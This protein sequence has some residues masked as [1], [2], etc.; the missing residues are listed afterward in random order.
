MR[1][2]AIGPA[3]ERLKK[4]G[5]VLNGRRRSGF[6]LFSVFSGAIRIWLWF[7]PEICILVMRDG[8]VVFLSYIPQENAE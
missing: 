5:K 2:T 8:E 4:F 1:K 7:R 3:D 6:R